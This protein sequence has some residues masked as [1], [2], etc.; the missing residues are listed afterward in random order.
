MRTRCIVQ[1][2][3]AHDGVNNAGCCDQHQEAREGHCNSSRLVLCL[4]PGLGQVL[5][6][7]VQGLLQLLVNIV[8]GCTD[9]HAASWHGGNCKKQTD[10][11]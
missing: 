1:L 3:A 5:R 9:S 8:R 6:G 4:L 7:A 11:V 2:T 10:R